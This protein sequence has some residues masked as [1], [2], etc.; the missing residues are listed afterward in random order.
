MNAHAKDPDRPGEAVIAMYSHAASSPVG[1]WSH[2]HVEC[3]AAVVAFLLALTPAYPTL[4]V[5]VAGV[6]AVVMMGIG[7]GLSLRDAGGTCQRLVQQLRAEADEAD[8]P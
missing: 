1:D 4:A 3:Y 6:V 5:I 2:R 8:L 7:V